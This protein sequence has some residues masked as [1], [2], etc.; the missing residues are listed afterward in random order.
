MT[1]HVPGAKVAVRP[2]RFEEVAGVLAL[3][4]RSIEAGC[5][6]DYDPTQRAAVYASCASTFFV[7]A[8]GPF[9]TIVAAEG[10]RLCG[11]AQL[12]P[13][14]KRLRALFVDAGYQ[15]RGIGR[16]L[17]DDVEARAVEHRCDRLNGAMA[18]NAVPFYTRAG[19]RPVAG[20]ENLVSTG[21][22]YVPVLRMEKRLDR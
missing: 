20:P 6:R 4:R 21:S 5:R 1:I 19:F 14:A 9:Q 10:D 7:D 16:A 18:L 15:G 17:L 11:I 22:V 8:V 12:D 2:L 13:S 3:I